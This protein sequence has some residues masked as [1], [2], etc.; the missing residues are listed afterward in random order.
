M[1]TLST[2]KKNPA[3]PVV[4]III[5][6]FND[7]DFIGRALKTALGQS[8]KNIEVI[9]VD[10]CSTDKSV[11]I[12]KSYEEKDP[13]VRLIK[14][15]EN[16]SAFQARLA[17]IKSAKADYIL[18]LDGDDE[19]HKDAAKLSLKQALKTKSD[20]VGFGSRIVRQDGSS[21]RD[22]EKSI[23][24]MHSKLVDSNIVTK[25]FE[26]NKPAQGS[27]WR[28]LF[29]KKILLKAYKY[30]SKG[31]RIYRTNDLPISFLCASLAKKYTSIPNRLYLYHFYAGGSGGTNFDLEKFKFYTKAVESMDLLGSIIANNGFRAEV[32][33][34]Y[35]SARIFVISNILRQITNNLPP[36]YHRDAVNFLLNKVSLEEIVFSIAS[37]IPESLDT[38]RENLTISGSIKKSKNIA[39]YTNNLH[40]GGVQGVVIS[41]ARYLQAAGFSVTIVVLRNDGIVFTIPKGI[42]VECVANGPMYTRLQSFRSILENNQIDTMIDH[43][44]L[45]NYSWPFFSLIAKSLN[46]KTAAWIHSFSLRPLTEGN[47]IGKFLNKNIHLID[48]L[49]VL[50]K[51]D[52]SYWKSIGHKNVYYL[53]NP[54]SP[55]LTENS[56]VVKP[57]KAPANHLNI[58]WFGRLQQSTKKVYSLIDVAAELAK[59]TSNF[60]LKIIGPGSG[61]L[62]VKDVKDRVISKKLKNNVK[63]MGPKHGAELLNEIKSSDIYASTS[64]IEGYQLTL[65]EAQSYALPV[66][67]YELPWLAAAENSEGV[68]Q[69]PQKQPALAAQEIYNLFTN[70]KLYEKKSKA[71]LD[72]SNKYLSYDFSQLY[73]QLLQHTL[74]PE[75]SPKIDTKHMSI[76]TQWTQFYFS[77]LLENQGTDIVKRKD[78]EIYA[79]KN[80]K[81]MK[82]GTT[83]ARPVRFA[84]EIKHK[85]SYKFRR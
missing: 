14:Q 72:A 71:S 41:Q 84:K 70:K 47:A 83:L 37:F 59:L 32:S 15:K 76:F 56:E 18:F 63:I 50:S 79:L 31:Q 10:D 17:G 1:S 44:I 30:F 25:L 13:R 39:L 73:T 85:F 42:K 67:M 4:S 46:I 8:L 64:I 2:R 69:T 45:Y 9:C 62:T 61:D 81:A 19:L 24:P 80:S 78:A 74:P 26:Q 28:F 43:N 54:P 48:D 27:L 58:I 49:V 12:V 75:F 34:S 60:T 16:A 3:K 22:F 5:P 11:E 55:L 36:K 35:Y 7:Q 38:I 40:T 20:M 52:V 77:E 68:I 51:P 29:T 65:L 21:S 66:V 82:L 23:Q 53:P 6:I 57:R 33:D